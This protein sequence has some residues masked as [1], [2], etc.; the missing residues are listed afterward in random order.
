MITQITKHSHSTVYTLS[1][2]FHIDNETTLMK[3]KVTKKK[4]ILEYLKHEI[5]PT[6]K[7]K[8][9]KIRT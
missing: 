4:E 6:D 3:T 8:A 7:S 1:Y 5:L 9:R 2:L